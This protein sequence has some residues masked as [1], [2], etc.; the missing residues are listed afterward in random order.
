MSECA[1]TPHDK[2]I[3]EICDSR[4]EKTELEHAAWREIERLRAQRDELAEALRKL[5]DDMHI[6][7]KFR[8][9]VD[10]DGTVVLDCGTGVLFAAKEALAKLEG[11]Q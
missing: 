10:P 1:A 9:D 4:V 7:A 3:A 6:R 2:L 5:I 8:G 11:K